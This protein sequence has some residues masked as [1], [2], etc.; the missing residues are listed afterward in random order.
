MLIDSDQDIHFHLLI[1]VI[2]CL[3]H[4]GILRHR[5][6]A[7][8]E[9]ETTDFHEEYKI[10][11]NMEANPTVTHILLANELNMPVTL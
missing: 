8:D 1:C 3:L 11:R 7:W 6:C 5:Y 10:M 2:L 4:L 9:V